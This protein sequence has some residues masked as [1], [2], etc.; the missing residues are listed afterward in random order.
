M[1]I[2]RKFTY[3][4]LSSFDLSS[5]EG[6]NSERYRKAVLSGVANALSRALGLMLMIISVSLTMPY[7]GVERFGIWMT[8]SSL[9]AV[10]SFLDLGIGNALT[11][12]VAQTA[13]RSQYELQEVITGGLAILTL[14]SIGIGGALLI[15]AANTPWETLLKVS[16]PSLFPEIKAAGICFSILFAISIFSVG[17]QKIFLGLQQAYISHIFSAIGCII[18]GI[19]CWIAARNQASITWLLMAVL[20]SQ[21]AINSLLFFILVYRGQFKAQHL[22]KCIRQESHYLFH[23]GLLFF[24][25]QIGTMVGW[26][27]DSLIISSTIGVAEV[28]V[29]AIVQRLFQFSIQPFAIM[30]APLWAAY[31]DAE[32]RGE[33]RFIRNTLKK[34]LLLTFIGTSAIVVFMILFYTPI[35]QVWT[36]GNIVAPLLLVILCGIWAIFEACGSAFAMFLNGT[37]V[38]RQQVIAVTLFILIVLPLK[39]SLVHSIG[40]IAIP[41]ATIV[42]YIFANTCVYGMLCIKDIQKKLF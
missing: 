14:L 2:F 3:L 34:S 32:V 19:L 5:E 30:N 39:L 27:A 36:H 13:I 17:C 12:R 42:A 9:V 6:R 21:V 16:D 41:L 10:L 8:I 25:L 23:I 26:G 24:L 15:I 40:I 38:V 20:G 7:L 35:I 37:G 31:A 22:F 4:R 11:N 28:A 33:K 1:N 18:G 29:F